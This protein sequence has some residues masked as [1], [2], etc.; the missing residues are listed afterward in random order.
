MA[1]RKRGNQHEQWQAFKDAN[2]KAFEEIALPERIFR[3]EERFV[4]FLN[5]GISEDVILSS[6]SDECFLNLETLVNAY[7]VDGWEQ[8]TLTAFH[9][10]RLR[11]F[12]RYG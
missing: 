6:M 8:T 7:I 3:S 5:S 11:R 1:F 10:E 9:S 12:Q 4:E 2:L